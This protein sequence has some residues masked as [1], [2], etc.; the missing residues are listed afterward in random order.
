MTSDLHS[1]SLSPFIYKKSIQE[2]FLVW[3]DQMNKKEIERQIS[4]HYLLLPHYSEN[5]RQFRLD[6][7]KLYCLRAGDE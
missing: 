2:K 4:T 7:T 5:Q 3:V 6:T 1:W